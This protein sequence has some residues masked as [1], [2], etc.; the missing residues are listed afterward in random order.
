MSPWFYANIGLPE[1]TDDTG[2][3]MYQHSIHLTQG[4]GNGQKE[5]LL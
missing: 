4:W 1:W 5:I 3:Q 2:K